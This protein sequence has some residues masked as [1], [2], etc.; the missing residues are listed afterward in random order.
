[1][2]N[3]TLPNTDKEWDAWEAEEAEKDAAYIDNILK[4]DP[5]V[6]RTAGP[7]NSSK[8]FNLESFKETSKALIG[9][10]AGSVN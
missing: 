7:R 3:I 8:P 2:G 4:N 6:R 5:D 10:Y 1:L 9:A